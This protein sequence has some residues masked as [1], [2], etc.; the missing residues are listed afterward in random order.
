MQ[1]V[2]KEEERM[3][4]G[5]DQV[6]LGGEQLLVEQVPGDGEAVVRR[7]HRIGRGRGASGRC[8]RATAAP[9]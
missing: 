4:G 2:N 8:R 9:R 1:V 6:D 5:M 3:C 7:Q